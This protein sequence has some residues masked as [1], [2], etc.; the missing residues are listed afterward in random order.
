MQQIAHRKR[1]ALMSE[2]D[3]VDY[4]LERNL[5]DA[6]A[7]V[8]GDLRLID[9]SRRNTNFRVVR[10]RASS[11]LLKQGAGRDPFVSTAR[12]AF[13]YALLAD[14]GGKAIA[15]L[16]PRV[17][18]FDADRELLIIELFEGADDLR[19]YHHRRGRFPTSVAAQLGK[20]LAQLHALPARAGATMG[21]HALDAPEPAGLFLHRPGLPVL[22][23]LSGAGTDIVRLIQRSDGVFDVLES[24]RRQW[25]RDRFIHHDM[26]WDNVLVTRTASGKPALK[27]ID[28]EAAGLGDPG[29][30]LG[31]ILGDYLACW[32]TSIPLTGH[33]T[34]D[35]YLGLARYP[36]KAIQPALGAL[37]NAYVAQAGLTAS[38]CRE[39]LIATARYTGLKL[40]EMALEHVQHQPE[41]NMTAVTL[42]QVGV[43]I[44][45][46]PEHAARVLLSLAA[47]SEALQ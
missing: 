9:A 40:M 37:W 24:M 28:W 26:R 43:N 10:E 29:W 31:G 6:A 44:V 5:I 42:V 3:V 23:D 13:V 46:S 11:Y 36:L 18:D 20:A 39:L 27:L 16:L 35:R 22:H 7:I 8:D 17:Y 4:L 45:T 34:P 41:C 25:R 14:A 12:E 1:A 33:D 38:E 2:S 15:R 21:G 19:A 30:D 32:I 47:P